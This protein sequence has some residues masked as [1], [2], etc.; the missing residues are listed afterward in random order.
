[1]TYT[2]YKQVRDNQAVRRSFCRLANQI[3]ELDFE[4]WYE[5]GHWTDSYIPYA[6]VDGEKVVT[7][8][9][10]NIIDTI[11]EGSSKRYIQV[12]TVMTDVEYRGQGLSREIITEIINDWQDKCEAI[13]LYANDT[14]TN[15]YP[16]FGFKKEHEYQYVMSVSPVAGDFVKLNLDEKDDI[17]LLKSYYLKSNPYSALSMIDNFGLVMFYCNDYLRNWVYYSKKYDSVVVAKQ[18][19]DVITIYDIYSDKENSLS[20]IVNELSNENIKQ[21]IIGFTPKEKNYHCDKIKNDGTFYVYTKNKNI[22]KDNKLR[23]PLLSHA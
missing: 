23:F 1:M 2:L 18:K 15:F 4:A 10:V 20:A 5:S 14:V 19:A 22:F 12:G 3:F 7:S 8:A 6:L 21:A 9:S 17:E 11:W 13:Y 16:K